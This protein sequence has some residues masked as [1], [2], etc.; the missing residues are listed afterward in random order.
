MEEE[1]QASKNKKGTATKLK[2]DL[3]QTPPK[4]SKA[5]KSKTA[6]GTPQQSKSTS[7]RK[8]E[9]LEVTPVKKKGQVPESGDLRL[10]TPPEKSVRPKGTDFGKRKCHDSHL[11]KAKAPVVVAEEHDP[12]ALDEEDEDANIFAKLVIR[13]AKHNRV[14]KRFESDSQRR[15]NKLK[16]YLAS[17]CLDWG[18]FQRCHRR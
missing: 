18:A 9:D 5:C 8:A 4:G 3:P 12:L 7:K 11:A 6:G 16:K 15:K 2:P 1:L 17:L 10:K 13:R 14:R